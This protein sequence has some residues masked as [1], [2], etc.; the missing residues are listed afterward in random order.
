VVLLWWFLLKQDYITNAVLAG[1][2]LPGGGT[3]FIMERK[4]TKVRHGRRV[5][6]R[7]AARRVLN[8]ARVAARAQKRMLTVENRLNDG[9]DFEGHLSA[10]P[11]WVQIWCLQKHAARIE[12]QISRSN[13]A[14]VD[15]ELADDRGERLI[16]PT[17]DTLQ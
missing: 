7:A 3:A 6:L 4:R 11:F 9:G 2:D 15:A 17:P 1:S 14:A 12:S 5:G 13:A 8:A 10:S 16:R